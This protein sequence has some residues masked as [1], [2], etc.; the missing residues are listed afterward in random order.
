VSTSFPEFYSAR[1][2]IV[3]NADRE[4]GEGKRPGHSRWPRVLAD[5]AM[6]VFEKTGN[7]GNA[8]I[9]CKCKLSMNHF[10]CPGTG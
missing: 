7:D 2:L 1:E 9:A 5:D 8:V 4:S 10:S 3:Q 6:I